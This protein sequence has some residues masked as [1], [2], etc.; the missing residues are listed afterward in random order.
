MT[1]EEW[2][3]QQQ[4]FTDEYKIPCELAWEAGIQEGLHACLSS[5]GA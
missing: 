3:E 5:T 2:W 4:A 1:F